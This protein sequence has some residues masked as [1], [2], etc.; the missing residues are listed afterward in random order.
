MISFGFDLGNEPLCITVSV[1][2][3]QMA[4]RKNKEY[5]RGFCYWLLFSNIP[6][7]RKDGLHVTFCCFFYPC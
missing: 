2:D 4:L 7:A 1:R 5:F 6:T 3:P